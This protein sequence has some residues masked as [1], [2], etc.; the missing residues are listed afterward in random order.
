MKR[1]LMLVAILAAMFPTSGKAISEK[2]S[3]EEY[4]AFAADAQETQ[5]RL[6]AQAEGNQAVADDLA[7]ANARITELEAAAAT[8]QTAL[9][10]AQADATTA[11]ASLRTAQDANVVLKAKADQWDAYKASLGGTTGGDG[12]NG[13]GKTTTGVTAEEA[14]A[15]RLRELKAKYPRSMAGVDVPDDEA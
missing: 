2:L 10:T 15:T 5:N 6:D 3:Q 11:Q 8:A 12:T 4:D 13:R 9:E 7:T 14:Q 1:N